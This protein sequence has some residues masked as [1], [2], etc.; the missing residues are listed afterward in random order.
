MKRIVVISIKTALAIIFLANLG[1]FRFISQDRSSGPKL[2]EK[3]DHGLADREYLNAK[4][5]N[6]SKLSD[7]YTSE[8]YFADMT[9]IKLREISN[10]FDRNAVLLIART[11]NQLANS[12]HLAMM[13]ALSLAYSSEEK[14]AIN[15]RLDTARDKFLQATDPEGFK[16]D[17]EFAKQPKDWP[18]WSDVLAKIFSWL[19]RAYLNNFLL[20]L[21]LLLTWLYQKE[22]SLRLKNPLS[23]LICLIFYPIVILRVWHRKMDYHTREFALAIE[24]KRR[25]VDVFSLISDNEWNDIKRFAKSNIKL[26]DYKKYLD[27]RGLQHRHSF[28]TAT[29]AITVLVISCGSVSAQTKS[30]SHTASPETCSLIKAPPDIGNSQTLQLDNLSFSLEAIIA[31]NLIKYIFPKPDKVFLPPTQDEHA[32]FEMDSGP[33]PVFC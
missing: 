9:D 12:H 3:V 20:A 2:P 29:F 32:G 10:Y 22:E 6:A 13:R 16:R 15:K 19:A 25:Q 14:D 4:I 17:Q 11:K 28:A 21:T 5:R 23:F 30:D 24:F 8:I 27:N 18:F 26:S 7:K 1:F 31:D 33:I